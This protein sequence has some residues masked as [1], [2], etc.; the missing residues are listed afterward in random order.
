MNYNLILESLLYISPNFREILSEIDHP[1]ANEILKIEGDNIENDISFIDFDED[2]IITFA[3]MKQVKRKIDKYLDY[4]STI[5]TEFL[6][7]DN[8]SIYLLDRNNRGPGVYNKSRNEIKIGKLIGKIFP[9]KYKDSEIEIFVNLLKSKFK[10][11]AYTFEIVDGDKIKECYSTINYLKVENSIGNSCMNDKN[12]FELYETN[13]DVCRLVIL[14]K[15]SKIAGRALLWKV[16]KIEGID[17]SS[18]SVDISKI[19]AE[20]LLDRIYVCDEFLTSSFIRFA[21]KNN[22]AYKKYQNHN[23]KNNII[24]KKNDY[25]HTEIEVKIKKGNYNKY[26]YMDTFS[27]LDIRDG[28]LFNDS[29]K[30]E[31]GHILLSLHGAYTSINYPKPKLYQKIVKKFRDF[32]ER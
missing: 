3:Q 8:D 9:N 2:G 26:P 7:N 25:Y 24:Y 29:N 15:N 23:D 6:K 16:D 1:I 27:R 4:T 31:P 17:R 10:D 19:S 18:P 22:W 20:F 21:E 11:N 13:K 30:D 12:F 5:D 14:K 28:I 32:L